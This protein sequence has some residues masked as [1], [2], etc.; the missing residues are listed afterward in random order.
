MDPPL[1]FSRICNLLDALER[2]YNRY[3]T[4]KPKLG[5]T[6]FRR[7]RLETLRNWI[8]HH[9]NEL[10]IDAATVYAMLSL[11]LPDWRDRKYNLGEAKTMAPAVCQ[12]MG[13]G[14]T[15][16]NELLQWRVKERDFGL[17]LERQMARRVGIPS[18]ESAD[19]RGRL[20]RVGFRLLKSMKTWIDWPSEGK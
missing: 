8:D 4:G 20:M 11:L 2:L 15:T 13:M 17:A 14:K 6:E 3:R 9:R 19:I 7:I 5:R 16:E 1:Q 12:A 18:K 10:F